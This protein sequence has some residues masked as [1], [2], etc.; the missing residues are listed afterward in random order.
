MHLMTCEKISK[1]YSLVKLL[2]GVD[3]SIDS[4]DK[5]GLIGINGTGKSTFLKILVGI[6]IG[7]ASCRVR[8]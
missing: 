4:N 6:E 5:I 3:Y 1:S 2:D 7:R 8:V